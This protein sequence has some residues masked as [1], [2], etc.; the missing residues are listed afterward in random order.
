MA[1]LFLIYL[2]II[3]NFPTVPISTNH[4]RVRYSVEPGTEYYQGYSIGDFSPD[5]TLL[6]EPEMFM[7][8]TVAIIED[9]MVIGGEGC[10][11]YINTFGLGCCFRVHLQIYWIFLRL[12]KIYNLQFILSLSLF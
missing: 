8:L 10:G 4:L 7:K 3:S 9:E 1:S 2:W 6:P 11:M 12:L 5:S